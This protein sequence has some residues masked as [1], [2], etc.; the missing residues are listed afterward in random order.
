[1]KDLNAVCLPTSIIFPSNEVNGVGGACTV[2]PAFTSLI[3]SEIY[4]NANKISQLD[5]EYDNLLLN[6]F[7][8]KSERGMPHQI[9][10]IIRSKSS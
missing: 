2:P 1:L 3:F 8:G 10:I 9:I 7:Q 6:A 4:Y 5:A